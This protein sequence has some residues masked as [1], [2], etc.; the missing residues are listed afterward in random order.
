[1]T[2]NNTAETAHDIVDDATTKAGDL[3]E[4]ARHAV[5]DTVAAASEAIRKLDLDTAAETAITSVRVLAAET[6]DNVTSVYKRHPALVITAVG[7]A[8]AAI[9]LLTKRR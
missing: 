3:A 4:T 8:L 1:M 6:A 2:D 9:A 7:V 5:D